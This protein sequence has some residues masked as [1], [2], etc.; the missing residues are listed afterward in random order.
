MHLVDITVWMARQ[1]QVVLVVWDKFR[2]EFGRV[3]LADNQA[4]V[5]VRVLVTTEEWVRVGMPKGVPEQALAME[6]EGDHVPK[7]GLGVEPAA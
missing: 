4:S 3:A 6:R 5:T 2:L 7:A 1:E